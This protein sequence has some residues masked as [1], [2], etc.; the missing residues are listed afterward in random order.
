M[1][2]TVVGAF[3]A[4]P[5]AWY[6]LYTRLLLSLLKSEGKTEAGSAILIQKSFAKTTRKKKEKKMI[7][8]K[9]R[10]RTPL[11]RKEDGD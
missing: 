10:N 4:M 1:D 3:A 2:T 8:C 7:S 5:C 11:P 6:D 9:Y